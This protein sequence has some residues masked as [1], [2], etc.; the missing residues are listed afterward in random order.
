MDRSLKEKEW[1]IRSGGYFTV[2]GNDHAGVGTEGPGMGR[3]DH[4]SIRP[5]RRRVGGHPSGDIAPFRINTGDDARLGRRGARNGQDPDLVGRIQR[6]I[7][8]SMAVDQ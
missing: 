2:V 1:Q 6:R 8:A 7:L 3:K 5:C 4:D